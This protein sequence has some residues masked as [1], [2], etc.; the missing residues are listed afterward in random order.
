MK[1]TI[2]ALR[3]P[4]GLLI[5][6]SALSSLLIP[7][8]SSRSTEAKL[9]QEARLTRALEVGT[10]NRDFDSKLNGLLTYMEMFHTQNVRMKLKPAELKEA[11]TAFRNKY[12][13]RYLALNETAWW[14]YG[15]ITR[16]AY[17]LRLTS[18]KDRK[19]LNEDCKDLRRR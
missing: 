6:G 15:D 17:L 10:H 7:W 3:H 4:L 18:E 2:E 1:R 16:E 9:L 12:T 8:I 5:L 19:R 13:E 11:Q 14:W